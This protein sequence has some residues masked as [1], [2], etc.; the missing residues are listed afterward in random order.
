MST[1][2][3]CEI[4]EKNFGKIPTEFSGEISTKF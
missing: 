1:M 3:D 4:F 2:T